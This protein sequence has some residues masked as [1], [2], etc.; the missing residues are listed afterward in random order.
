VVGLQ[1]GRVAHEATG[2]AEFVFLGGG[3]LEIIIPEGLVEV[4]LVQQG[5]G[6]REAR[7]GVAGSGEDTAQRNT[8]GLFESE[9]SFERDGHVGGPLLHELLLGGLVHVSFGPTVVAGE[10]HSAR[11]VM[12]QEVEREGGK[13]DLLISLGLDDK[14]IGFDVRE[15]VVREHAGAG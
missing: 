5:A 14:G 7:V 15:T 8:L 9:H 2:V 12:R 1:T 13:E 4:H 6:M 3:A 11:I 10:N